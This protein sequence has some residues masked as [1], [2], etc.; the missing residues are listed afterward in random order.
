MTSAQTRLGMA[1]WLA[2]DDGIPQAVQHLFDT[3]EYEAQARE[4]QGRVFAH[5]ATPVKSG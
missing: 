5:L 2:E 4:I 1:A 3:T